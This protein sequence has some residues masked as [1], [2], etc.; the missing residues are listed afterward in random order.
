MQGLLALQVA[1]TATAAVAVGYLAWKYLKEDVARSVARILNERACK[2]T[3]P[4]YVILIRHGESEANVDT[5]VYSHMPD[6]RVSLTERGK[7]QARNAGM[8]IRDLI[9]EEG[10]I[11]MYVSPFRRCVQTC[12]EVRKALGHRV[13]FTWE[14]P[15]IREQ[16]WG[17]LQEHADVISQRRQR[18]HVG[19]FYYRFRDGESG[20]DVYDR[21]SMFLE[22]LFRRFQKPSCPRNIIIVSH[23]LA[24][25]LFLMRYF[26]WPVALFEMSIN[27]ENAEY[28]IMKFCPDTG[29]YVLLKGCRFEGDEP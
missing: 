9:G 6:H 16:E 14:D 5:S 8:E 3:Y 28:C 26:H 15:R 7:E 25:R 21:I 13:H 18:S 10:S 12:E 11:G 4:K 2:E 19:R 27:L 1:A 23:G 17:N 29:K 20:A 24:I 22:S